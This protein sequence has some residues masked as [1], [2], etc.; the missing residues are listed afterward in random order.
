MSNAAKQSLII[1]IVLLIGSFGFAGYSLLEKQKIEKQKV[2]L[3]NEMKTGKAREE[4]LIADAKNFE[5]QVKKVEEEKAKLQE[6]LASVDQRVLSFTEEIKKLTQDRDDWKGRLDAIQKERDDLAAKLKEQASA[7]P[8]VVYKYIEKEG[9]PATETGT[10]TVVQDMPSASS[11]ADMALDATEKGD[12]YWAQVLKEKAE[13]EVRL[14]NLENEISGSAID[15][16]ELKKQN[17][18]LQMEITKLRDEKSAIEREI[19]NGKDL[20]D[21]LSLELARAKSDK[22]YMN[23][24]VE[25]I[26][27][28]ND[29]L[30]QQIK[31]LSATKVALE[32]N[33]VRISDEKREL[34]HKLV[35]T[36]DVVQNKIAEVWE[37]KESITQKVKEA[38]ASA[39]RKDIELPP[40]IVNA[41]GSTKAMKADEVS[42]NG[43][44]HEEEEAPSAGLNGNVL[45][46]NEDNNFVI[47][48][49]GENRGITSG[50]KLNIYR[51]TDYIAQVEVIQVRADISAADIKEKKTRIKVGDSVR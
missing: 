11:A 43:N 26:Q 9:Q 47:V 30:Q 1:L 32:K 51:G 40:I 21:T 7:E 24:R 13:L 14:N 10:Q 50:T 25:K 42:Y 41:N 37:M 19:K 31:Q 23:E 5:A 34:E 48:D 17:S 12:E 49:I 46:I 15:V 22:K 18:D 35:Q 27:A 4:K 44:G 33:I 39:N 20:A 29:A 3:E 2:E 36:E 38:A 8:K 45:S 6:E 16:G 28:D